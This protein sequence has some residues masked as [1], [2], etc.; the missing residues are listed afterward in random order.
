[1]NKSRLPII[2]VESDDFVLKYAGEE[3]TP[4]E[5]E[6]VWFIPYL[7]TTKT[8]SLLQAMD[9]LDE[10]S[11]SGM[12]S[13]LHDQIAPILVEVISHWTWT[14]PRTGEPLGK[15]DGSKIHRPDIEAVRS[16][17]LDE[18]SYLVN[19]YFEARGEDK[20]EENPQ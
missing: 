17:S 8:L 20:E 3:Y 1:M 10:E 9:Q 16:L 14:S 13:L 6:A 15:V 18:V 11:S 12:V 4:H 7:S 5:G 2:K 19:A